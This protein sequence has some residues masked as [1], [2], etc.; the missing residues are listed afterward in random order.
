MSAAA[1]DSG[2]CTGGVGALVAHW[3]WMS[4]GSASVF[5]GGARIPPGLASVYSGSARM[6]PGLTSVFPCGAVLQTL[7]EI[8]QLRSPQETQNSGDLGKLRHEENGQ[9]PLSSLKANVKLQSRDT[10]L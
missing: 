3:T 9:D 6:P 8:V 10:E 4:P 7:C 2:S 1:T 5:S